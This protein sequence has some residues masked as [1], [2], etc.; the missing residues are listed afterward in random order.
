MDA[1]ITKELITAGGVLAAAVTGGYF[2]LRKSHIDASTVR[3][4]S[5]SDAESRLREELQREREIDRAERNQARQDS[6]LIQDKYTQV[7]NSLTD[8]QTE[9][10]NFRRESAAR[11]DI[12]VARIGRLLT[13][14]SYWMAHALKDYH[15]SDFPDHPAGEDL[16]RLNAA[17]YHQPKAR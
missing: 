2:G 17:A 5:L 4:K 7:W 6:L 8:V 10:D 16:D 13:A 3:E 14:V 15:I 9:F 11:E 12:L 1:I